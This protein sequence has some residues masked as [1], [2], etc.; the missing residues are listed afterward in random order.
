MKTYYKVF[1]TRNGKLYPA[2]AYGRQREY[3]IGVRTRRHKLLD[4]PFAA[5]RELYDAQVFAEGMQPRDYTAT[6]VIRAVT[7]SKPKRYEGLWTGK[8]M[9]TKINDQVVFDGVRK[10]P[11]E[12][13]IPFGTVLLND[14][15]ILPDAP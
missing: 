7:G 13:H 2:T 15:T 11:C 14:F 4:G 6:R 5:F 10:I 1:T 8:R 3:H 9:L 12:F